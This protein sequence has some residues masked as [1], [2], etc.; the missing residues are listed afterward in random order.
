MHPFSA[1]SVA[2][3]PG[4][5]FT[6]VEL[7][8]VIVI[9]GILAS[10]ALPSYQ[11]FVLNQRIKTATEELY[12]SISFA[13]SEAVM[14]G[15]SDTIR[16]VPTDTSAATDWALGWKINASTA[17]TTLKTFPAKK[18]IKITGPLGTLTYR[19][20]GRLTT[21]SQQVFYVAASGS[22]AVVTQ[23]VIVSP[24]GQPLVRTGGGCP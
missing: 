4:N 11:S 2:E 14:R 18:S 13:R 1:N 19:M 17:G 23:C 24:S 8:V 3:H 6:L 10:I 16:I 15:L 21:S 22:T 5:G 20:D 7:L 9:A 12:A